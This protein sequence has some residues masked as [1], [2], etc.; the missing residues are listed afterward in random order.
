MRIRWSTG[1]AIGAGV[2]SAVVWAGASFATEQ[3]GAPRVMVAGAL[4]AAVIAGVGVSLASDRLLRAVTALRSAVIAAGRGER[5]AGGVRIDPKLGEV[6]ECWNIVVEEREGRF[7]G[8]LAERITRGASSGTGGR[9]DLSEAFDALSIGLVVFDARGDVKYAN[10]AAGMFLRKKR[11]EIVG[12]NVS[13]I[14]ES[15]EVRDAIAAACAGTHRQ[16]RVVEHRLAEGD[17]SGVLRYAVRP[18]KGEGESGV[19]VTIEDVTQ[20][21]AADEARRSMVAHAVHE[22]RTPLTN[23]RLYVEEAIESGEADPTQ[24]ARALNVINA[25]ARRLER[26]VA[27][28]LSV[29]EMESGSLSIRS[30]EVPLETMFEDLQHDYAAAAREKGLELSWELPPKW[31]RVLGDRDKL[32][33]SVH[34]LLGNA[35]KYTPRGGSITVRVDVVEDQLLVEVVDTGIGISDEDQARLF[36]RFQRARDKRVEAIT[37]TGLGLALAREV[38]RMHGGDVTVKSQ[39]DAGSTFT[40]SVPTMK[41]AA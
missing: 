38:A 30:A 7:V 39:L 23:I 14:L 26:V 32:A 13:V 27:D 31:P 21:R 22:L 33:L 2:M 40:L 34:N 6:A 15:Q 28:M 3:F 11:E 8:E 12:A 35:I 19:V 17:W 16:R 29:S 37:G 18:T 24:T 9:G 36:E 10:G 5:D 1:L 4:S 25:E 41:E 20:Q